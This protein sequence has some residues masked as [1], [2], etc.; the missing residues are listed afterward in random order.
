MSAHPLTLTVLGGYLL[1]LVTIG[2][3][4]SRTSSGSLAD[5]FLAGRKLGKFTVALSAV[6]SGRSAWLVLGVTGMAY[7]TGLNAVWALAGFITVEVFLFMFL[8]RRVRQYSETSGSITL[9]D[10]L[11]HRFRDQTGVLRL[12]AA[13]IIIFFMIAYVSSQVVAGG[14]AFSSSLGL[15]PTQGM[16]VTAL[17]ILVYTMLGGFHAVS[18]TDVLQAGFMLF[19]L[20]IVPL[21]AVIDLGGFGPILEAM[22]AQGEGFVNPWHFGFGAIAGLLGIG[23]G[24]PGN[25]HIIVRY[26]AL[27]NRKEMRKAA[28]IG[29]VWNVVMGWGAVILGL[30]GRVYFP[31]IGSL[32]DENQETI[33]MTLGDELFGPFIL[34][35][36]LTA[37]LAAIMS[38]ADSQL[39]VA[40]SS[41]I[42]DIYQRFT[43]KE[44]APERRLVVYS[45]LSILLVI[46]LALWLAFSAQEFVFWLVLFAWGGLGAALGPALIFSMFWKRATKWGVLSGMISGLIT[47]ILVKKQPAWTF[48]FLPDI[49]ELFATLLGGITYEAVPGFLVS[50]LVTVVVSLLTRV[51]AEAG[52]ELEELKKTA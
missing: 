14:S 5:F 46:L 47:V 30:A 35:L 24:S 22:K 6:S 20:V 25:P 45:R 2:I 16:W 49:K 11:E 44:E 36:L 3:L 8:A 37:V 28:L 10:I 40:S 15:T 43:K 31:D 23:F 32:P 51:P 50:T 17:I 13:I 29:S 48:S 33:F 27:K 26:M 38:S 19:S 21:A 4:T 52:R 1:L 42:R 39:L 7:A 34:G 9:T 18:K 12:T 41:F